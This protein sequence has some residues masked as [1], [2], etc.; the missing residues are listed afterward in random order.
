M[1]RT[2]RNGNRQEI[3]SRKRV[4]VTRPA[5]VAALSSPGLFIARLLLFPRTKGETGTAA[6]AVGMCLCSLRVRLI[7]TANCVG[8]GRNT[9]ATYQGGESPSVPSAS[10]SQRLF[11]L[12]LSPSLFPT[13]SAFVHVHRIRG[14]ETL[15]GSCSTFTFTFTC[16]TGID[17]RPASLKD[18]RGR[19][20]D[21]ESER[22]PGRRAPETHRRAE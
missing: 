13:G 1:E 9:L 17:P 15:A 19:K 8:D 2:E 11:Y 7:T 6:R 18:E 4:I 5:K 10:G 21:G 22:H 3:N 20:R 14:W 12:F 16:R